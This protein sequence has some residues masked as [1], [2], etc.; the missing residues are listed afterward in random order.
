MTYRPCEYRPSSDPA[1]APAEALSRE[2]KKWN[3]FDA[4]EALLELDNEGTTQEG[5]AMRC[6]AGKGSAMINAEGYTKEREEYD[7]DQDI[8]KQ[9]GSLKQ[10][11]A[12]RLKDAANYKAEGNRL[13]RDGR[14]QD[15]GATYACG[16]EALELCQQASVLMSESMLSKQGQLAADLHRNLAAVQLKLANFEGARASCD[17]ALECS[18]AGAG[19][20]GADDEKAR[21][22]RAVALLRLGRVED[23][24]ADIEQLAVGRGEADA[25]VRRLRAETA[26][27]RGPGA[28][29]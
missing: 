6:S 8:E 17:R 22:R 18:S 2:Y 16:L 12:Q 9:M 19:R 10:I 21:Y 26:K 29:Q 5:T 15:A 7:L 20:G 14:L 11:I 25:I 1:A 23:A 28:Q 3:G 13:L 27:N 4:D 24:Q